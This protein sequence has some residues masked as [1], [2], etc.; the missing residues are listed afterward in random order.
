MKNYAAAMQGGRTARSLAFLT[1]NHPTC[2]LLDV[3]NL[4]QLQAVFDVRAKL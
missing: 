4:P 1:A 2:E 3:F